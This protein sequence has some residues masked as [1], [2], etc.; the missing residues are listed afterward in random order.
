MYYCNDCENEFEKYRK[1][2][3]VHSLDSPPYE[4]L[5][6]CPFCASGDFVE[7]SATHC[8]SCGAKLLK[9]GEKYCSRECEIRGNTLKRKSSKRLKY[10]LNDPVWKIV[11]EIESYNKKRKTTLSYGTY[12]AFIEKKGVKK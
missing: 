1:V 3:E 4:V 2:T 10:E 6:V 11:R 5:Y 9:E 7:I 12:V 8:R